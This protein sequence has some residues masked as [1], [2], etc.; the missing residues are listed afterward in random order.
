VKTALIVE[1][2]ARSAKLLSVVLQQAGFQPHIVDSAESALMMLSQLRFHVVVTE[3]ALPLMSGLVLVETIRATPAT[4]EIPV[5]VATTHGGS[6]VKRMV[7]S[8]GC[9]KFV[10]KPVDV[11]SF[12]TQVL[13]L[14]GEQP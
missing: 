14:I 7:R 6:E 5:V 3:L 9:N 10:H 12:G 1:P 11:L 4:R 13:E 8:A 2:D